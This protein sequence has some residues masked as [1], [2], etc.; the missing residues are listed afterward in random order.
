M[1]L[2]SLNEEGTLTLDFHPGQSAAWRSERRFVAVL[3]G[4]QGGKTSWLPWWLW[5]EASRFNFRGDYLAATA[6]YDLFKLKFLPELRDVFEEIL[7]IA[8][9]WSGDRILELRNPETGE[10]EASKADDPMYGRIILRSAGSG[11]GLESATARAAILDE[12]GQDEFTVE[13]WE[14]VLRRLSLHEGRACL[15]TTVYNLGWLKTEFYDKWVQGDPD[16]D[17]VQFASVMNPLFPRAEFERAKRTMPEWRFRMFYLGQFTRPAGLIYGDFTDQMVVEPFEIPQGWLRVAGVDFGGTNTAT[18]W[19]AE[20]PET[21]IWYAY[22][23]T[24]EGDM[25]SKEHA[26]KAK[27]HVE[28]ADEWRA[29]GGAPGETQQ[30][31]DF[32]HNGFWVRQ[33]SISDVESGIDRVTEL[34][35]SGQFRVF[36]T[37]KGLRDELGRYRRV[38]DH[39]GDPTEKIQDKN[40]FHRLDALRYAASHIVKP[41]RGRDS[42]D[43]IAFV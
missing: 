14:A 17:V 34:I 19:L 12:A 25:T 29:F 15:A 35:K 4:T 41:G 18:V 7:G 24:L 2:H 21:R 22:H 13:T 42:E 3:A 40:S 16:Y 6:S 37:L 5:R 11:G 1:S 27:A 31:R 33:P 23:E 30:R 26:E 36:R 43:M 28:Q 38:T 10:F 8:R 9:Y 39:N 20:D 32:T